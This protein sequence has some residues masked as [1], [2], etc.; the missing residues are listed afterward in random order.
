M[1]TGSTVAAVI[2]VYRPDALALRG[3][4][5]SL[6]SAGIPVI[7]VDDASPCTADPVL[8][9]LADRGIPVV[10]YSK[11]AGIARS[12]NA[13]LA[14]AREEGAEWL[15]T[16]DQDS[17][18]PAGYAGALLADAPR[19]ASLWSGAD[20]LRPGVIGAGIIGDG[21]GD[22][23]YPT[24]IEQG[25]TLTDEVF[26]T[27]S[28]W[29]IAALDEIGGFH[30][31]LGIDAVDAAACL[32]LRQGGYSVLVAPDVRLGH[33]LGTQS[34]SVRILGRDVVATGH[35][36][37]RRETMV[38][39]RLRL[40]PAEFKESPVHAARTLRRVAINTALAVTVED[41]RWAKAKGSL[42]G[43]LPRKGR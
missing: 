35:S 6:T 23:T 5:D 20:S 28:L 33:S 10:R 25:N 41:D 32:A 21:S 11:N 31:D 29:S 14:F 3:L 2:P 15:L 43:L 37:A 40:A 26:Q 30:E 8:R 1:T 4:L 16:V 17:V 27:G 9:E 7:V 13:G 34:R 36:P 38:R 39:N 18:L 24:R 12:L 22:L 42:R 19:P